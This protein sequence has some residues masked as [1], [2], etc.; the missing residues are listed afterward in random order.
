MA[1]GFIS[2]HEYVQHGNHFLLFR[3][4]WRVYHSYVAL[5]RLHA[6]LRTPV[7]LPGT[8]SASRF[9]GD[10]ARHHYHAGMERA[11]DCG[12]IGA[13][14]VKDRLS[15]SRGFRRR[16]RVHGRNARP[17]GR[18]LSSSEDGFDLPLSHGHP[19]LAGFLC[20]SSHPQPS[21]DQQRK[22]RQT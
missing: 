21:G 5:P 16:R 13:L 10:A 15:P 8:G 22:R 6:H 14:N 12:G 17:A 1:T 7:G 3:G 19:P 4:Q 9:R 20:Q 2:R 18:R 11:G